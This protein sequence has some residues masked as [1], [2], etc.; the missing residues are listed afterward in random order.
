MFIRGRRL[1]HF[2]L[3][4][5]GVYWMVAF[6]RVRRLKE[7]IRYLSNQVSGHPGS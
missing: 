7:E 4:K 3:T 6:V 5:C 1:F 2:S